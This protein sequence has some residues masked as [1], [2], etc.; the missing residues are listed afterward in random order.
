MFLTK[1]SLGQKSTNRLTAMRTQILKIYKVL[2]TLNF[3]NDILGIFSIDENK[4]CTEFNLKDHPYQIRDEITGNLKNDETILQKLIFDNPK[5]FPVAEMTSETD[6]W[7]PLAREI[8]VPGQ[9]GTLDIIATDA[10]GSIY[11]VEC[12]LRYNTGDMKTIRGQISDYASGIYKTSENDFDNFW[13]WLC[14]SIEAKT[15]KSLE[16]ILEESKVPEPLKIIESMK[17]NFQENK[18]TLVFAVDQITSGLWDAVEWHNNAVNTEHNFPCFAIEVRKYEDKKNEK[19]LVVGL[20][21]FPLDLQEIVR[22]QNGTQRRKNDESSWDNTF[23]KNKMDSKEMILDF[24]EQLKTLIASDRGEMTWGSGVTPRMMPKFRNYDDR[25]PI[26]LLP[27][28]VLVLQFGLIHGS[29]MGPEAGEKFH[30]KILEINELKDV[31]PGM[32]FNDEPK[33]K[34]QIWLQHKEKI[35]SILEEIFMNE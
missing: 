31:I 6:K 9:H 34:P 35:L 19:N 16:Q 7:I 8:N 1:T 15:G 22:R 30:K 21:V 28:G 27:D 12:K 4:K 26:G 29:K 23:N 10:I 5:I 11:I 18:I 20:Q 32:S 13:K 25:S 2:S 14:K 24:K 33:I 3:K 17:R